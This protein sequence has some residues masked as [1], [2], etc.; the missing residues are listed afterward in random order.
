MGWSSS[1]SLLRADSGDWTGLIGDFRWTH[2]QPFVGNA[3]VPVQMHLTETHGYWGPRRSFGEQGNKAIYFRGSREQKS[4]TEGNKRTKAIWGNTEQD[5]DFGEQ[6]KMPIFSGEQGNRYPTPPPPLPPPPPTHTHTHWQGHVTVTV[7]ICK[8]ISCYTTNKITILFSFWKIMTAIT[9]FKNN[10]SAGLV[11]NRAK[12]KQSR[13]TWGSKD[14]IE[15]NLA[16]RPYGV[17]VIPK[18]FMNTFLHCA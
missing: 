8:N 18:I 5:F 10:L 12:W 13:G 17:H 2:M 4:K 16:D 1:Q 6:G 11:K 14:L 15:T 9:A 7:D 3:A